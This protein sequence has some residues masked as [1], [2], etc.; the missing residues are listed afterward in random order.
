MTLRIARV[1]WFSVAG[2]VLLLSC[3]GNLPIQSRNLSDINI[4]ITL[5][6]LNS[7]LPS[8]AVGY[9][10]EA[11][12]KDQV[13]FVKMRI[14]A[15]LKYTAVTKDPVKVNFY[16]RSSVPITCLALLGYFVC[17]SEPDAQKIGSATLTPNVSQNI[18]LEGA[19]LDDAVHVGNGYLGLQLEQ[20]IAYSTDRLEFTN[21]VAQALL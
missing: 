10:S 20:G 5:P 2:A 18:T 16:A 7:T 17:D 3:G 8:S 13:S 4:S 1:G 14:Y 21:V 19:A 9:L 12:I 15:S 11:Q 6:G